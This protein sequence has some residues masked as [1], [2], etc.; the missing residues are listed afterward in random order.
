MVKGVGILPGEGKE[1][2]ENTRKLGVRRIHGEGIWEKMQALSYCIDSCSGES[3][4]YKY[5]RIQI[6]LYIY[7]NIII[8]Y[9]KHYLKM[10]LGVEQQRNTNRIYEQYWEPSFP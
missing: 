9:E 8:Y 4:L 5:I 1:R 6:S 7:Y 10:C 2:M 3:P